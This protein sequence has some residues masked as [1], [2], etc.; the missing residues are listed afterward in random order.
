MSLDDVRTLSRNGVDGAGRLPRAD[1]QDDPQVH[2][3]VQLRRVAGG[4]Q[5][6]DRGILKAVFAQKLR[7]A[8]LGHAEM[9]DPGLRQMAG[10]RQHADARSRCP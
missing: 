8:H 6:Q 2:Q 10:Q 5:H 7:L 3:A 4:A 1:G 9:V